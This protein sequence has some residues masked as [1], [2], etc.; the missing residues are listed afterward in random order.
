VKISQADRW[1]SLCV[2]LAADWTCARCGSKHEEKSM[3][4]H[5]S[6]LYSR[7]YRTIRWEPLNAVAHCFACH[8]WYGGNP[9]ESG[10]WAEGHLGAGAID[11]LRE[12]KNSR[13]RI[14]KSEEK[15]IAKHYREEYARI[16][17]IRDKGVT[18]HIKIVGYF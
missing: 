13:Q 7:R 8:N 9:I 14:P 17:A 1:F 5:C 12:K 18:G 6:H 11:I 10:Q 2:R 16:Q 15:E 4:L 3:G